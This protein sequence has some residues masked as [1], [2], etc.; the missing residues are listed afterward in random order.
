ME[1]DDY[2]EIYRKLVLLDSKCVKYNGFSRLIN[3]EETYNRFSSTIIKAIRDFSYCW[4]IKNYIIEH[5]VLIGNQLVIIMNL[6]NTNDFA[7]FIIALEMVW[8]KHVEK[9]G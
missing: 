5:N 7:N 9:Y 4:V 2:K 3:Y 6:L 8:I 1:Y